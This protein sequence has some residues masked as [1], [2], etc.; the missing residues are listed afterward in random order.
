[1]L[2]RCQDH[3]PLQTGRGAVV[4]GTI[5]FDDFAAAEEGAIDGDGVS[6]GVKSL[7]GPINEDAY[8]VVVFTNVLRVLLG[9]H[10]VL[11]ANAIEAF[12]NREGDLKTSSIKCLHRIAHE[13]VTQ[14][15][16]GKIPTIADAFV[17]VGRQRVDCRTR[18]Q[19]RPV[20]NPQ[21]AHGKE[22]GGRGIA[23]IDGVVNC[24]A[25]AANDAIGQGRSIIVGG[26]LKGHCWRC[27]EQNKQAHSPCEAT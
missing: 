23:N 15:I 19:N 11:E 14:R 17:V 8:G 20:H 7:I 21:G 18:G 22:P 16:A 13:V 26:N 1:M 25:A 6:F 5:L 12:G 9:T 27:H 24:H 4:L 10:D 3:S 2:P